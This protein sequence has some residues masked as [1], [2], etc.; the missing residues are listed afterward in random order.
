[1]QKE[2]QI[3]VSPETAQNQ[4]QLK[5]YIAE[6]LSLA[7]NEINQVEILKRS[8]DARQKAVKINLKV[9]VFVNEDTGQK[10]IDFPD[11]TDVKDSQE[12]I[13]DRSRSCWFICGT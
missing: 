7:K 6:Q 9:K 2:L 5:I 11:Y 3:Q 10:K 4:E 13:V 8:I 1:M 12:V